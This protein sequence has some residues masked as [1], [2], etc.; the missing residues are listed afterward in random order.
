MSS[1]LLFTLSYPDSTG[2]SRTHHPQS[3]LEFVI[4]DF[5]FQLENSP[6]SRSCLSSTGMVFPT[7]SRALLAS[8]RHI[9]GL[10]FWLVVTRKTPEVWAEL[11]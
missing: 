11:S 5:F 4:H 6:T 2:N 7:S 10:T 8:E 3:W 9:W 1:T